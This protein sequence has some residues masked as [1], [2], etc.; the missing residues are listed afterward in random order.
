MLMAL[1]TSVLPTHEGGITKIHRVGEGICKEEEHL[2]SESKRQHRM[3]RTAGS[4]QTVAHGLLTE[5][6]SLV[7]SH[8]EPHS[9]PVNTRH[10]G[11]HLGKVILGN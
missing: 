7:V 9:F 5:M 3:P 1:K 11:T 2:Q 10:I 8:R 6:E 4:S